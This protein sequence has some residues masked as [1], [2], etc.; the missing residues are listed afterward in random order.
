MIESPTL[1]EMYV[2]R[3]LWPFVLIFASS[4]GCVYPQQ[5]DSTIQ[6]KEPPRKVH[7]PVPVLT[8]D[9]EFPA[10]ARNSG[11]EG[12]CDVS[13]IVDAKG[14]PQNPKVIRCTNRVF[15]ENSLIA[16]QK[17]RFKPA[18]TAD[19][20]AI[21]VT[22]TVEVN[23]R[24]HG[25]ALTNVQQPPVSIAYVF[26]S[27]PGM[28]TE[29]PDR[30][31]VY[32]L[33]KRLVS[34]KMIEFANKGFGDAALSLP[35]GVGCHIVVTIDITG[36]ASDAQVSE[37]DKARLEKPAIESILHSRYKP[38]TLNGKAVS[39]RMTVQLTYNGF[40]PVRN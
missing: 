1:Q 14:M 10:E 34:P 31:G 17:Y 35:E 20:K 7:A 27:P 4:A 39:V 19:G 5:P 23:F 21:P 12:L 11:K 22:I 28:E 36:K 40:P 30:N 8:P 25:G 9:A 16:V 26:L 3:R 15:A 29:E 13:L 2:P 37:C 18:Q 33:S 6:R 38:A 32:P 24:L